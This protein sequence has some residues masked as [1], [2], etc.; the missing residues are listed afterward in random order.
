[1]LNF[2][3]VIRINYPSLPTDL[4]TWEPQNDQV[5]ISTF[6]SR[7]SLCLLVELYLPLEFTSL[8]QQSL[9]TQG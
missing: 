9:K 7:K 5:T 3:M 1:M 8:D 4:E 2:S 6:S